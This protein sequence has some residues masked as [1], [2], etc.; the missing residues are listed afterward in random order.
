[1][2]KIF[3]E[4][5][6]TIITAPTGSAAYNIGG[7]TSHSLFGINPRNPEKDLSEHRKN[8]L[9]D[10]FTFTL[11]ILMDE[12][13]MNSCHVL[14]RTERNCRAMVHNGMNP[15]KPYGGIPVIFAA[16]DEGQLGSV[17]VNNGGRGATYIFKD[18]GSKNSCIYKPIKSNRSSEWHINES[19]GADCFIQLA[20]NVVELKK[21]H[22]INE[23]QNRLSNILNHMR[24]DG[25]VTD[26]EAAFLQTLNID[27]GEVSQTRQQW[28]KEHAI[29]IYP[30]NSK[31]SEKNYT[32]MKD[33]VT[34]DNPVCNLLGKI[35]P[36]DTNVKKN[37]FRSH[38]YNDDLAAKKRHTTLCRGAKCA[39]DRNIFTECGV[40]NGAQVTVIEIR[41]KKGCNPNEGH[42]PEY[43][44][45]DCPTYTGP[46]WIKEHPQW[47]PIPVMETFCKKRCCQIRQIPLQLSFARTGQKFQGQQVGPKHPYKA[48]VADIGPILNEARNPGYTYMICSRVST[49]GNGPTDSALYFTGSDMDQ[50]RLTD[51]VTRRSGGGT[52]EAVR[53]KKNWT[54]FLKKRQ[55]CT[56]LTITE[57]E[58]KKLK[59]W[60]E[61]TRITRH[62]LEKIIFAHSNRNTDTETKN[63]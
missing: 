48:M 47:I 36:T 38:F 35:T 1:M 4:T 52:Y 31:V 29:W 43:V 50:D 60:A 42:E 13:T 32:K 61:E 45:V 22:R 15:N 44:I 26:E 30:S 53:N 28:L 19:H 46:H 59:T 54:T 57:E 18:D 21:T 41:Y 33:I 39:I 40:F 63:T 56:D 51:M 34:T 23:G 10:Q 20:E 2:E 5:K 37:V 11:A 27:N 16:G 3:P 9:K 6:V 12:R 17:N 24:K 14:G 49:L 7:G 55:N 8:I 25:G 62:E 58:K